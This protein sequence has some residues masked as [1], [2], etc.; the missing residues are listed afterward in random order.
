ME[1]QPLNGAR[2]YGAQGGHTGVTPGS[3]YITARSAAWALAEL[4]GEVTADLEGE[5]TATV[6]GQAT[7]EVEGDSSGGG[8]G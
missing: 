4:E 3:T 7:A 8:D 5:P 1:V 2:G 6:E